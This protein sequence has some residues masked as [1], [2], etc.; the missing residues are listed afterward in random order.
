M[1]NQY[2]LGY[3]GTRTYI[4]RMRQNSYIKLSLFHR[5]LENYAKWQLVKQFLPFLSEEFT[6][7][8][9]TFTLATQGQSAYIILYTI[10]N[11]HWFKATP[12]LHVNMK[13]WPKI[14]SVSTLC[15]VVMIVC[16]VDSPNNKTLWCLGLCP[17]FRACSL[18]GCYTPVHGS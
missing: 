5:S 6:N 7:A 15:L 14:I 2:I 13:I 17:L 9:N 11:S 8:Y 16:A 1:S 10:S 18:L 4:M 12:P 3:Y